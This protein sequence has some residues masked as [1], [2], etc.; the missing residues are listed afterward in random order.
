MPKHRKNQSEYNYVVKV[1]GNAQNASKK[2][3]GSVL[4]TTDWKTFR[5]MIYQPE[6]KAK[7]IK[8]GEGALSNTEPFFEKEKHNKSIEN[9]QIQY[10]EKIHFLKNF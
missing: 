2:G 5:D 7:R 3:F 9:K 1:G 6:S 4:N 8:K 10:E